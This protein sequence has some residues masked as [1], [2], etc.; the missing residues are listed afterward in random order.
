MGMMKKIGEIS[1][2]VISKVINSLNEDNLKAIEKTAIIAAPLI[3]KTI[4]DVF[5]TDIKVNDNTKKT[6]ETKR[7]VSILNDTLG[8][9]SDMISFEILNYVT[10]ISN[11]INKIMNELGEEN[12]FIDELLISYFIKKFNV[13]VE[14]VDKVNRI[15]KDR[16]AIENLSLR[17]GTVITSFKHPKKKDMKTPGGIMKIDRNSD[18][19]N[20]ITNDI[21]KKKINKIAEELN[22]KKIK[23]FIG[24]M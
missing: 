21:Y 15:L 5:N 1:L 22:D 4:N 3:I 7:S 17:D 10:S 24:G 12:V 11:S 9:E 8:Y 19:D 14:I 23:E 13:P 20:E 6:I 16:Y 2:D 18:I